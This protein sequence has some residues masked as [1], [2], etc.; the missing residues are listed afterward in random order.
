MPEKFHRRVAPLVFLALV[1]LLLPAPEAPGLA[2]QLSAPLNVLTCSRL[3]GATATPFNTPYFG[4]PSFE[5]LWRRTDQLVARRQVD[6]SWYWGPSQISGPIKE[7]YGDRTRIVQYFEKTRMELNDP[8]SRPDLVTNGLLSNE[9][10]SGYIQVGLN[11]FERRN[12]APYVV[13]GDPDDPNITTDNNDN[14]TYASFAA[15]S[16]VRGANKYQP[17]RLTTQ[18]QPQYATA[19]I[20]RAGAVGNDPR[21]STLAFKNATQ[22]VYYDN[23]TRHNVP[24][25]FWDYLNACG[26]IMEGTTIVNDRLVNDPWWSASGLPIS[27][28]YWVRARLFRNVEDILVQAFERRVLTFRPAL[29]LNSAFRVEMGN[30]GAHY[31]SWRYPHGVPGQAEVWDTTPGGGRICRNNDPTRCAPA[32]VRSPYSGI[33]YYQDAIRVN[34]TAGSYVNARAAGTQIR[35]QAGSAM[36]LQPRADL[37]LADSFLLAAGTALFQHSEGTMPIEVSTGETIIVP[38]GT[39]FSVQVRLNGS[40]KVVVLEGSLRVTA[41]GE[42][43]VLGPGAREQLVVPP[44]GPL[45]PS[46]PIDAEAMHLWNTFGGGIEQPNV[47][48][49]VPASDISQ[50]SVKS[51]SYTGPPNPRLGCALAVPAAYSGTPADSKSRAPIVVYGSG[52]Q[53]GLL[54]SDTQSGTVYAVLPGTGGAPGTWESFSSTTMSAVLQ[55]HPELEKS[56]GKPTLECA[57]ADWSIQ[58]FMGGTVLKLPP[59]TSCSLIPGRDPQFILYS[60]GTWEMLEV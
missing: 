23:T 41:N 45:P 57:S 49:P 6:R 2:A 16:N 31:V 55:A 53:T 56:L 38:I 25:V 37:S 12:P 28:A 43:R 29:P 26:P 33:A 3:S 32:I 36:L 11:D 18:P 9:L 34:E 59:L 24:R 35:L 51:E 44:S 54:V 22:I 48:D 52:A 7:R 17:N 8:N 19:T 42:E 60:D 1:L 46:E 47:E 20:N 40:V 30:I 5:R 58:R 10:I 21:Y 4:H 27:D 14:P 39:I 13:A 15:V 50:C